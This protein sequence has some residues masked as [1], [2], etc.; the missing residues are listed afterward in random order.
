MGRI[1]QLEFQSINKKKGFSF[2]SKAVVAGFN[3][4][5]LSAILAG[6]QIF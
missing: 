5:L 4:S 3:S 6:G 2:I 1:S